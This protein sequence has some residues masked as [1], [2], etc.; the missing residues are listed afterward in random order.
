[1]AIDNRNFP[2]VIEYDDF[3]PSKVDPGEVI[4]VNVY[5]MHAVYIGTSAGEAT[6]MA[7]YKEWDQYE[8]RISKAVEQAE[9]T[10]KKVCGEWNQYEDR[11]SKAAEQA[12]LTCKKVY[13]EWNQYEDRISKTAEQA[14]NVCKEVCREHEE[15][16]REVAE[17][18]ELTRKN[19]AVMLEMICRK[20]T[21]LNNIAVEMKEQLEKIVS[22]AE[23]SLKETVHKCIES[24]ENADAA[25][26]NVNIAI[27][28]LRKSI[29]ESLK[30]L[31]LTAP[32]KRG[33]KRDNT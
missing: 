23:A 9:F 16:I 29:Q 25:L 2:T 11:I 6:R 26:T 27:D 15:R 30:A 5:G 19:A 24:S 20:E 18:A 31:A 17:Q 3:D 22:R 14:E 8:D 4:I 13:A 1:M 33:N 12:E 32:K 28:S 7:S 21:Q 10:C